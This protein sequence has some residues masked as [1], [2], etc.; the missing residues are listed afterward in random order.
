MDVKNIVKMLSNGKIG[1][2]PTDTV[3][4]IMGDSTNED[5][6]RSV[7]EVKKRDY[8]KPL[9]IL[10][11]NKEMLEEYVDISNDLERNVINEFWPGKVTIILKKKDNLS[12]LLTGGNS[13]VGVRMPDNKDL[14]KI[15]EE[16]GKPIL[17]T[18]ANI[19]GSETIEDVSEIEEELKQNVDFIVDG[20]RCKASS[21]TIISMLDGNLKILRNGELSS[22]LE[23]F[24]KDL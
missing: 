10:V 1:I 12:S 8:A 9:L 15:I 21:S 11:S 19:S 18:S 13:T 3:Y 2:T 20:G 4:G 6:I 7:Y 24:N 23:E 14:I 17:S 16:F 5:V 22:K